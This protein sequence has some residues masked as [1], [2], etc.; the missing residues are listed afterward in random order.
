MKNQQIYQRDPATRKLI[1]EGVASVN[2]FKEE[3]LRYELETFVCDG[4]YQKGMEDIL[5]TFLDN[6]RRGAPQQPGSWISGF[7]GSGKSHLVKML[8]ALWCN[9]G[10]QDGATALGVTQLPQPIQDLFKELTIEARRHGGLHAASGTLKANDD[11]NSVRSAL[12]AII[13]KSVGLPAKYHLAAFVMWLA[14]EG[15]RDLLREKV[16]KAGRDWDKEVQRLHV[17]EIIRQGLVELRP[18]L[19]FDEKTCAD[20]LR[21]QFPSGKD[22]S[23]DEMIQAIRQALTRDGKFPLTLVILDEVQQYIG[24]SVERSIDVQETVESCSKQIGGKLMF[25]GTGQTAVTGTSNLKKL[26]GR[27]TLRI[28]L[29]DT[30]V[31]AV[32]RKVILAKKPEAVKPVATLMEQ[33]LGEISRQLAGSALAHRQDDIVHFPHDYP[34]LPVRRRFW[35]NTLR[36]LDQTGTDSQLRNQLTM[37]HKAI[38][39]NL[40]QSLGHVIPGDYLYFDSA[41]KLLQARILPRKVH[42]KTMSWYTS[43]DSDQQLLARACGLVF[44]I[45][46]LTGSNSEVG[47]LATVDSLAD[48]LVEDLGAGSGALRGKLPK[49]LKDCELLMQVGDEYRIQTEESALW[50]DE[51]LSQ[52]N[53]LGNEA[54]RLEAE[55]DDRI[56][57]NFAT[58][59]KQRTLTQGA[60]KVPREILPVFDAQLPRDHDKRVHVWVRDGWS[61]D[62]NSV[63]AEALQ[64]GSVSPTVFVFIPKRSADDLRSALID[65]KAAHT[66]L[67]IRGVPTSPE[68]IEACSAMKTTLQTAEGKVN[69]LLKEA[70]AGAKVYQG[71]GAEVVGASLQEMVL[72]AAENALQRL[73]RRFGVADHA[74]WDKVYA[75]ARQGAPDALV[76]VGDT[77]E[78]ASNPVCKEIIG[79]IAGGK[80]G[81]DIRSNFQDPP[82]GWSQDAVDGALQTLLVAGLIRAQDEQGKPV[83]PRELERKAIGK[84]QYRVE[85]TTIT[86]KQRIEIRKVLQSL[87]VSAKTGEE[88][89]QVPLFLDK[90]KTL[91]LSAGGEAPKPATPEIAFIDQI[92]LSVGNEQLLQIFTRKDELQQAIEDWGILAKRIDERWPAWLQLKELARQTNGLQHAE[93]YRLQVN[94]IEEQRML[95][96]DPDP[97]APLL[98]QISQQ[99]REE[100]NRLDGEYKQLHGEGMTRLQADENWQQLEPEQKN[101]LLAGQKLSNAYQPKIEVQTTPQ[102]LATLRSLPISQFAD[103][104]AALP[105]RF[106]RVLEQAAELCEP[107]LT[108][109]DLPKR[110]LGS[111]DELKDYL[112]ELESTI[113][114]ALK[115]GPVRVR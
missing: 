6:V 10:F 109:V 79:F 58:Q 105:G 97:G 65:L 34:I 31:E 46:K 49:L 72:E 70:F 110:S 1:N 111:E 7:Y 18:K 40:G 19:F 44:L 55:R 87:G 14:E 5:R 71:G 113:K 67:E 95:L 59:V 86:V 9:T 38:Q 48:L 52:K 24:T 12:L 26:E 81:T 25:I 88:L 37:I 21:Q 51:Y 73:Y 20:T 83:D 2:D 94:N 50:N 35:E 69:Q 98:S 13:F 68:G 33:N 108:F 104:I 28:E 57:Q 23:N 4:Q 32:I 76:A 47:L 78:P 60:A 64:A 90:L 82:Y 93:T 11:S 89:L 80:T 27:F 45:N 22:V 53:R 62:E 63:R 107:E 42:E 16:E 3:V 106:N 29:S 102:V 15:L 96:N 112:A 43:G 101:Q 8:Q 41:E 36:V 74:G 77:G 61:A 39:S 103:Q 66:T 114:S 54:Y 56:K 100:L 99:L 17:S 91:A 84:T 92:R 30:D 115:N 85:A 75:K